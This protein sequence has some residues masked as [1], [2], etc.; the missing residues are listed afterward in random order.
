MGN[1]N[2]KRE[3]EVDSSYL[4][5]A[6]TLFLTVTFLIG[7]LKHMLGDDFFLDFGAATVDR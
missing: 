3:P 7:Q 4:D 6:I 2:L 5:Y 1:M